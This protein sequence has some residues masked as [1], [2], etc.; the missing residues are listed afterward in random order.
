VSKKGIVLWI[1]L[2]IAPGFGCMLSQAQ[3]PGRKTARSAPKATAPKNEEEIIHD[4]Q[5]LEKSLRAAFIDGK[6]AWWDRHLD[7]H[8]AGLNPDGNLLRK[9]DLIRLYSSPDLKYQEVNLGDMSARIYDDCVI[10]TVQ[11]EI[12]GS[13]KGQ[14]FSGNYYFVHIWVKEDQDWKL[15]Q[16]QATRMPEATAGQ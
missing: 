15:A 1:V 2:M 9:T 12:K 3:S 8:Y 16:S 7:E 10:A 6:S 5:E 4:I 13:Y 11:S 14:D